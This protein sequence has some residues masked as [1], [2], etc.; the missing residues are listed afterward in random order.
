VH[1]RCAAE[2][3]PALL[4]TAKAPAFAAFLDGKVFPLTRFACRRFGF[5]RYV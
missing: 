2:I 5:H 3:V 4:F 1:F